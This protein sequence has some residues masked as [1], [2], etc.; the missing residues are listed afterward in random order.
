MTGFEAAS[1]EER[2]FSCPPWFANSFQWRI[3]QHEDAQGLSIT[4]LEMLS[5]NLSAHCFP[6]SSEDPNV[7]LR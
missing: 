1:K 4:H 6:D 3:V 7:F 2:R 5:F